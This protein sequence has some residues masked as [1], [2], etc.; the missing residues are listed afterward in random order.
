MSHPLP[1]PG[2]WSA[3]GRV[4]VLFFYRGGGSGWLTVNLIMKK[5]L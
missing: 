4:L 5:S 1:L 3:L 2:S